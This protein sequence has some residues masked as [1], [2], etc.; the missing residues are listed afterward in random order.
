M[1]R[2]FKAHPL[3]IFSIIKPFL[4]ILLI[5]VLRGIVQYIEN[6]KATTILEQEM[7]VLLVIFLYGF[8][9]WR[10][11]RLTLDEEAVTVRDG[12]FMVRQ[13]VIP[14]SGLSSVQSEQT[15]LDYILG[16]VTF[17]INTEAGS[18]Q[19]TDYSF[20]LSRKDARTV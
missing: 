14:I 13:A 5:P 9:R 10:L 7:G 11:F 2:E 6:R 16:S 4:F 12:L 17:R 8:L 15:P 18:R 19:K 3:M 1:K 20:K